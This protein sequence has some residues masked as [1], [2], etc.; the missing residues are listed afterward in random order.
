[1]SRSAG[2]GIA[3]GVF[4]VLSAVFAIV[5]TN[6][7]NAASVW[8]SPVSNGSAASAASAAAM[9]ST[10]AWVCLAGAA[11]CVILALAVRQPRPTK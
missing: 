7:Y 5:A 8:R 6:A 9:P 10:L 11:L 2:L 1:M 4:G 3:A